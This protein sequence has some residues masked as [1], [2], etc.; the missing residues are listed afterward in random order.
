MNFQPFRSLNSLSNDDCSKEQ[1][2]RQSEKPLKYMTRDLANSSD[3][4]ELRGLYFHDGFGVACHNIENS[5]K[6]SLGQ[7]NTNPNLPQSLPSLPL[8]TTGSRAGGFGQGDT[9][10]EL[11]L[12]GQDTNGD[13]TCLPSDDKYYKRSFAIFDT[14]C[15]KPQ[16]IEHTVQ[17]DHSFRGGIST[18][19]MNKSS[20]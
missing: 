20:K 15:R 4:S 5:N 7:I 16:E 17:E 6:L 19:F 14:V 1:Q 18:R 12:R 11:S 9:D 8:P 2:K 10:L 3:Q 13:K